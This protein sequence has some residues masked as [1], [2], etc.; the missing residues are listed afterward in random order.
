VVAASVTSLWRWRPLPARWWRGAALGAAGLA[1]VGIV[2]ASV[3]LAD[4]AGPTGAIDSEIVGG[5]VPSVQD[6]LDRGTP[7]LV[8][9]SDPSTLGATGIGMVLELE[10][11]GYH[12]GVDPQ[13]AAAALPHR[14]L[15]EQSAGA[16]LYVVGGQR[17]IERARTLPGVV[18]LGSF[19]VRTPAQR[20]RS[21]ELRRELEQALVASGHGDQLRL[22]DAANGQAMLRFA[23]PPLPAAVGAL[24]NEY[25]SLRLPTA[26]FVAPPFTPVLPLE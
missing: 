7:Y 22:L 8:R 2:V 3:Q 26:V 25:V 21:D 24:L 13:F 10:R 5:L 1:A 16:V 9:W 14:V 19:D 6:Q 18:E 11:R 17:A 12:V 4:R 20:R 15:P 23:Y